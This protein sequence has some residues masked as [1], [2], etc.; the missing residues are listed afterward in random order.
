MSS[1][2]KLLFVF[3]VIAQAAHSVE[4]YVTRLFEVFTPARFVSGLV[5]DDL[6]PFLWLRLLALRSVCLPIGGGFSQLQARSHNICS[7]ATR[8]PESSSVSLNA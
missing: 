1:R 5:S 7:C 4:E 8:S 2:S 6:A 3:L